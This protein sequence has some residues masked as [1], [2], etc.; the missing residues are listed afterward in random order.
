MTKLHMEI[1]PKGLPSQRPYEWDYAR[2]PTLEPC[3]KGGPFVAT[4]E[5]GRKGWSRAG[6]RHSIGWANLSGLLPSGWRLVNLRGRICDSEWYPVESR[7]SSRWSGRGCAKDGS[8]HVH[9]HQGVV[10]IW[11][12]KARRSKN[13]GPG[14]SGCRARDHEATTAAVLAASSTFSRKYFSGTAPSIT[15][16]SAAPRRC[17]SR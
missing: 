1:E 3:A 16:V 5:I 10:W 11:K 6:V 12:E 4:G 17:S 2:G 13:D 9:E 7:F 14:C 8:S 15:T